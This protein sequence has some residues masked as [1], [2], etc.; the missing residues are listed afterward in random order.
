[1]RDRELAEH[2]TLNIEH[3]TFNISELLRR[4]NHVLS[5][6]G[7]RPPRQAI[8]IGVGLPD[9]LLHGHSQL[10]GDA[11]DHVDGAFDLEVVADGGA[12]EDHFD[13]F[14][15]PDLAELLVAEDR[16]VSEGVEELD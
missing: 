11:T 8:Q 7:P 13:I 2:S 3:L 15:A 4:K 14:D 5:E 9:G 12:V 1:M 10:S 16:L 6:I